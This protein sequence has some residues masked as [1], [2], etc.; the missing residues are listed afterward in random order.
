MVQSDTTADEELFSFFQREGKQ[1][2]GP[3]DPIMKAASV[4][5]DIFSKIFEPGMFF[6]SGGGPV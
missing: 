6:L 4:I 2:D 1:A 3:A 5:N